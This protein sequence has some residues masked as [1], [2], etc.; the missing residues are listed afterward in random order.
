MS[1][2]KKVKIGD[3]LKRYKNPIEIQDEIS[4][5]RVTIRGKHKGISLR[6]EEVGK[7]IGTKKQFTIKPGQFLLSKIDARYG[8]FGTV[9]NDLDGAIITGDF[10]AYDVNHNLIDVEFFNQ[11]TNSSS[12]Y[13]LCERSSSGITHRKYLDEKKF[14]NFELKIPNRDKQNKYIEKIKEISKKNRSLVFE[15]SFQKSHLKN[16]RQQILQDAISGKLTADWRAE[17]R[18]Y[19]NTPLRATELLKQIK[20]EKEK[21]IAEKKIK[22]EKLLPPISDEEI[23]FD[24]PEGWK[25][26][27][28]GEITE[29][30][31]SGSTPRGGKSAYIENG[32]KFIRSQNV[33]NSGLILDDIVCIS[34]KIHKKMGNTEVIANDLLLNITGGSIGRCAIVPS[35]FDTGNVNQHVSVIRFINSDFSIFLHKIIISNYFQKEIINS[36]TGAGREGLPKYKMDRILIPLPP[37]T[38]QKAIVKKV[39]KLMEQVLQLEKLA[40]KNKENAETLMQAFLGDVFRN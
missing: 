6:D 3:F 9:S 29:R 1:N 16:L 35:K 20:V 13:D 31:G 18:A 4:Y 2:W 33:Y 40:V 12:F 34:E 10:W 37:L 25:W 30:T 32:I 21:L 17:V 19:G 7:K 23:P 11:F 5:K 38:E 27:R 14:L 28:L 22:K 36:Q 8:A 15:N 26:C 24:L 39:E